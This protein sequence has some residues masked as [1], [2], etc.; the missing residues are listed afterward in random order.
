MLALVPVPPGRAPLALALDLVPPSPRADSEWRLGCTFRHGK[1][2]SGRRMRQPARARSGHVSGCY[3]KSRYWQPEPQ[4]EARARAPGR[5]GRRAL[6][7]APAASGTSDS[8]GPPDSGIGTS[9]LECSTRQTQPYNHIDRESL[10]RCAPAAPPFKLQS[11]GTRKR[12]ARTFREGQP[13]VRRMTD[14]PTKRQGQCMHA[15]QK[16]IQEA[17]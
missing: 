15:L 17:G 12:E 11:Q 1:G 5:G 8:E 3:C 2:Q 13:M 14:A 6:P 7:V 4:A 9:T 10:A 16:L